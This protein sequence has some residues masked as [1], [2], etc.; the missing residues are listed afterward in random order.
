MLL[1]II[2]ML[3][4]VIIYVVFVCLFVFTQQLKSTILVFE[5]ANLEI[6]AWSHG[7]SYIFYEVVNSYEFVRMTYT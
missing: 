3:C 4:Y 6:S 7:N 5:S 1:K 2:I